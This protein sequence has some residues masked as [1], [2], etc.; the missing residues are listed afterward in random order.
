TSANSATSPK[1]SIS[2]PAWESWG[3][4]TIPRRPSKTR[5]QPCEHARYP[6][7][8]IPDSPFPDN[9]P[10]LLNRRSGLDGQRAR[11][12]RRGEVG[13]AIEIDV[14]EAEVG[15]GAKAQPPLAIR[16]ETPDEV[17]LNVDAGRASALDLPHV[18]AKVGRSVNDVARRI[19]SAN[20]E[21]AG[22]VDDSIF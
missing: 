17:A 16:G 7:F 20:L 14:I 19:L 5:S 3:A 1:A 10:V 22:L 18:L 12:A 8:T 15:T 4:C 2:S 6:L 13:V 11:G 21:S 9:P